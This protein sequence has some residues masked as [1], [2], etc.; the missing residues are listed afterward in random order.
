MNS[1]AGTLRHPDLLALALATAEEDFC[2]P[3]QSPSASHLQY[4]FDGADAAASVRSPC[5]NDR[6]ETEL[7]PCSTGAELREMTKAICRG[8][9]AAFTRF[10]HLYNLRLYRHLLVLAKGNEGEAREV[11]QAVVLKVAR[12]FE[13]FDEE[14]RLWGWL[15]RL[16]RNAYVDL[17]RVRRRDQRFIPLEDYRLELTEVQNGEHRLSESLS[18]AL[19][20]LASED[21]E[22]MRAAY[23]DKRPLQ[24]LAESSGQTYKAMESRLARLR[25]KVKARLLSHLRHEERS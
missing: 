12:K 21:R 8:D 15:C 19:E 16:A 17:C 7:A 11:L 5:M 22:L 4:A 2:Q 10:Y 13:I 23:V 6:K 1:P 25:Q 18:H 14:R 3:R 9:E 20:Q 24:E